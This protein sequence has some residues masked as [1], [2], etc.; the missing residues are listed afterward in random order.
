[1][2]FRNFNHIC[3][4]A[5]KSRPNL[6]KRRARLKIRKTNAGYR[7]LTRGAL[8]FDYITPGVFKVLLYMRT[9]DVLK[10]FSAMYNKPSARKLFILEQIPHTA[11]IPHVF[12]T[13]YAM[14]FRVPTCFPKLPH[15][16]HLAP[17]VF[18][19]FSTCFA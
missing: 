13:R 4:R 18:R 7:R 9:Q 12:S 17:H 2:T 10:R 16:F 1:M 3:A 5:F 19:I 8:T 6:P 15:D 11:M 14:V